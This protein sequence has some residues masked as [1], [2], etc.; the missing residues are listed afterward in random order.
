MLEENHFL[1]YTMCDL[2]KASCK[3]WHDLYERNKINRSKIIIIFK[4]ITFVNILD[5][6]NN[7]L[8]FITV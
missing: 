2:S 7:W 5:I 4:I 6:G 3:P 8:L 1:A